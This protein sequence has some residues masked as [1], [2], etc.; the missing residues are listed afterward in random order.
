MPTLPDLYV[1]IPYRDLEQL[2][3][4]ARELPQ[5]RAEL[6]RCHEQMACFRTTQTEMMEKYQDLYK[7]I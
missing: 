5:V 1:M 2:L 3:A 6:A 4:A 7:M